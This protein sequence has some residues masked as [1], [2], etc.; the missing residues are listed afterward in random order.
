MSNKWKTVTKKPRK[1]KAKNNKSVSNK[2]LNDNDPWKNIITTNKRKYIPKQIDNST[3]PNIN[4]D[5]DIIKVDRISTNIS[6]KIK[7]YRNHLKL[8]QKEFADKCNVPFKVIQSYENG[9][10]ITNKN[11]LKKIGKFMNCDLY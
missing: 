6:N 11:Y 7:N 3:I 10:G 2:I 5:D 4:E 1:K 9:K 8:N